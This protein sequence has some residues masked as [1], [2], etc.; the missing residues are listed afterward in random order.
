MKLPLTRSALMRLAVRK[1]ARKRRKR[2]ALNGVC[3]NCGSERVPGKSVCQKCL[4]SRRA[5][6][7]KY[8]AKKRAAFKAIGVCFDCRENEAMP[9]R[10]RCGYCQEKEQERKVERRHARAA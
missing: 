8:Q 5:A 10:K 7:R 1:C 2:F 4:D 6:G 3:S 9:G